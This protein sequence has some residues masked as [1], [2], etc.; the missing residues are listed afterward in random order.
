MPWRKSVS[1]IINWFMLQNG[2]K[3][4]FNQKIENIIAIILELIKNDIFMW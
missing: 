3:I 2:K 1:F 4:V